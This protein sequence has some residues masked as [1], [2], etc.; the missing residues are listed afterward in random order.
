MSKIKHLITTN[1]DT[2]PDINWEELAELCKGHQSTVLVAS[3]PIEPP[4]SLTYS[5]TGGL[6]PTRSSSIFKQD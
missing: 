6:Y 4:V 1:A 2:P 5:V 3:M